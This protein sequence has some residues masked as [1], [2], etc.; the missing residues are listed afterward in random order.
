[1]DIQN[2]DLPGVVVITPKVH[3]DTRGNFQ[4]T[5]SASALQAAGLP[6]QFVQDNQSYSA[7]TGTLR[8]LHD[9]MPPFAQSKLVRVL[10]GEIYDV[11]VDAR[12]G[13]D[14]F[15]TWVGET[16]S[17]AN[18]KQLFIPSGFLH[19]FV[20]RTP[21]TIVAYK[22]TTPYHPQADRS[23][24]FDDPTLNINWGIDPS[25]II[26]SA[27]DAAA[28]PFGYWRELGPGQIAHG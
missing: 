13:S 9:Q 19:G 18:G 14:S 25:D 27:K 2:T 16:L 7:Q 20:T 22:C 12:F 5:Y 17:A 8:G 10:Q 24:R 28:S 4:E 26:L 15:G 11:A 23:I 21:N 1:M 6:H 3:C